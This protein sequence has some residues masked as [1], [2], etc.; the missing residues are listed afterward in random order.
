MATTILVA[1]D[2]IMQHKLIQKCLAD[3]DYDPIAFASNGREAVNLYSEHKPDVILLDI[4]MPDMDG[5]D[6]LKGIRAENENAI[7]VMASS[8]GTEESVETALRA[9]AKGFIQKPYV[10]DELL[11]VLNKAVS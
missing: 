7:V 10:R 1:D 8:Y 6:A 2:S 3:S 9:G 4:V 11:K 5:I